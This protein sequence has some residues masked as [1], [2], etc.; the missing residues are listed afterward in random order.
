MTEMATMASSDVFGKSNN[1]N[2]ERTMKAYRSGSVAAS[3]KFETF[4]PNSTGMQMISAKD[5]IKG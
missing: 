2:M 5:F 1:F 4:K 3:L